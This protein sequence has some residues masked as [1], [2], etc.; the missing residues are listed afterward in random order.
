MVGSLS[1]AACATADAASRLSRGGLQAP[2][3]CPSAGTKGALWQFTTFPR[4]AFFERSD[5]RQFPRLPRTIGNYASAMGT[6]VFRVGQL[7]TIRRALLFPGKAHNHSYREAL[8]HSS[9]E[10][11]DGGHGV[12]RSRPQSSEAWAGGAT[13]RSCELWADPLLA[14][15]L[16]L[17]CAAAN[18]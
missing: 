12:L 11:L 14:S 8:L 3:Q 6:H 15:Q 13:C 4:S 5:L 9:G 17:R 2:H 10:P 1:G 7:S 16:T 18:L